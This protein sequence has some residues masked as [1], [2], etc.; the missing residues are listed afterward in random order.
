MIVDAGGRE[1][2]VCWNRLYTYLARHQQGV[3]SSESLKIKLGGV[4]GYR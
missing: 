1:K 4:K 2:A 3:D